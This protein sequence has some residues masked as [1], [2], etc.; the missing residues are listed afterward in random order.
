LNYLNRAAT[1]VNLN[2]FD[3]AQ[4]VLREAKTRKLEHELVPWLSYLIAFLQDDSP[5]MEN[6]NSAT[7]V[8]EGTEDY[9]LSSQS[10]TEAFHGRLRS[11]RDLSRRAVDAAL[12]QGSKEMAAAWQAHVAL[13]EA[14]FGYS[15]MAREK[16]AAA[17]TLM[18][19]KDVQ[20]VAALALARAG[21]GP[22]AE[23]IVKDLSRRFPTDTL[24]S[25]YWLPSIQAAIEIDRKRPVRAIEILQ[26]T[27]PYELGGQP[28]NLDTLYPVYLRGLAYLLDRKGTAAAAEFQ[29]ILDH[30]GR[31]ANGSLGVLAYL[32][33]VK[34]YSLAGD[35]AK[36]QV[37]RQNLLA[38][39]KDA[40]PDNPI[41]RDATIKN[42][43]S[44]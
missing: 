6:W 12:R 20:T 10:D 31:V 19:G 42:H 37:A 43:G 26:V 38:L 17:L 5:G 29:K 40:D 13:R 14:E 22:K 18:S 34:A 8:N 41:L 1:Y 27:E 16:A 11:A 44:E 9:R 36:A 39:W 2:R 23:A 32:Q 4:A 3:E 21:D 24:L 28:I 25:R 33:L 30:K 15:A 7:S 35:T